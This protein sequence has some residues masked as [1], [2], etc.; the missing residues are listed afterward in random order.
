MAIQLAA[1]GYTEKEAAKIAKVNTIKE[2]NK[3][4]V[5]ISEDGN[6][7]LINRYLLEQDIKD[8]EIIL[9]ENQS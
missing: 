4:T 6:D 5:I 9:Y 8:R 3:L 7:R 2:I 1:E